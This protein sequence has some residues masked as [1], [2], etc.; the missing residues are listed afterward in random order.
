MTMINKQLLLE[1]ALDY[2]SKGFS[3]IPVGRNKKP[4]IKWKEFQ[5]RKPT[6]GEIRQWCAHRDITGIAIV[7]GAIS[8]IV[9]IDVEKGGNID[10]LPKTVMS[11]TGGGGWH[12]YYPYDPNRPVS[13]SGRIR[14]IT[15]VRG[16]GGYV[17]APPSLHDSGKQYVWETPMDRNDLA[18]FPYWLLTP[19]VSSQSAQC[20]QTIDLIVP[21]G[22]RNE[23]ATKKAGK[24]LHDL[25]SECWETIGWPEFQ[26]WNAKSC[27][28][29]LKMGELRKVWE[30]IKKR[31]RQNGHPRKRIEKNTQS[32][33]EIYCLR[34]RDGRIIE[35]YYDPSQE[36]T[37]L[38]VFENGIVRKTPQV[39]IDGMTYTAPPPTNNLIKHGFVHLPSDA[40]SFG[41]EISLLEE[42]KA[43]I[44]AYVQ[45]PSSFE[46][47]ST[48]YVLFSWVYDHFQELPY[49]RVIGDYGSGK[50]RFLKVMGA[51][52]YRS[53]FLNGAASA[54]SIF[55]IIHQV[56]GTIVLDEADFHF[57]DT[58]NELVKIL[59]SGF[60]KGIPVFRSEASGKNMKSF[61]PTPFNVFGP[62]V[63]ATRKDFMDDALESRCL[64]HPMETL[65]R[66]DIPENLEDNFDEKALQIRNKLVMFRFLKLNGGISK[67]S[68]PKLNIEP[69]LRQ[70]IAP[71]YRV[72]NAPAGK[73]IILHFINEKQQEVFERRYGSLEGE[74]LQ[75]LIQLLET[76][77]E[78]TMKDIAVAYNNT[79]GGK[80]EIKP[81]KIGS[82][83]EKIFHLEKKKA[84]HGIYFC[85][86]PENE[87]RIKKLKIKF[88]IFEPEMN[89]VNDVNIPSS[90]SITAT[91]VIKVFNGGEILP[92]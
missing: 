67:E 31:E 54:S 35:A 72:I 88:G 21:H 43:L 34:P 8:G 70:I 60:Q 41:S 90:M 17:I 79:F 32:V 12:L 1:A 55:R 65:T 66:E 64:S 24:I 22:A 11:R 25:N 4:L 83:L 26:A 39:L 5:G 73:N 89:I 42:I 85:C 40:V 71:L 13:T 82:I 84:A 36:E 52:C 7:T 45:L 16:D 49:L 44:H 56:K 6:E 92:D 19:I 9:V 77:T 15:D 86:T 53:I 58:N 30:S 38:L 48:F 75:T 57:S 50:S 2:L 3:I 46:D 61:D 47:I 23:T 62:K 68:L 80:Y 51:L 18:E 78:P 27:L 14:D 29:P 87:E 28:P 63:I 76:N 20:S 91:D 10:D 74:V 81:K 59:N 33:T 69:R 37:G